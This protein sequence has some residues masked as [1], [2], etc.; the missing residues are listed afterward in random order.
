MTLSLPNVSFS[1]RLQWEYSI[2]QWKLFSI[3]N[4]RLQLTI[5]DK[6]WNCSK[7][8]CL[9]A[10]TWV[11]IT[12]DL[13]V[14]LIHSPTCE[15]NPQILPHSR[16]RPRETILTF[17]RK[18]LRCSDSSLILHT[19]IPTNLMRAEGCSSDTKKG[20]HLKSYEQNCFLVSKG[21]HCFSSGSIE[22]GFHFEMLGQICSEYKAIFSITG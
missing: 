18:H 1:P 7:Q 4:V 13:P 9:L 8:S 6:I 19:W 10:Q 22:F 14:L 15:Q 21:A 3:C 20:P 16:C 5:P 12:A 17:E 11:C 2:P